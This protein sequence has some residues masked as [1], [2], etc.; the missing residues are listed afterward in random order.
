M[1]GY[2]SE[3]VIGKPVTVLMPEKFRGA[4][5]NHVINFGADTT[6]I[7][8][9]M[10]REPVTGL[11]KNGEKFSIEASI[12]KLTIDGT[13]L[14]TA[15]LLDITERLQAE[16]ELRQLRNYLEN[17]INSMP[18]VLIG[19]DADGKITQWNHQAS[20]ETDIEADHAIGQPLGKVLPRYAHEMDRIRLAIETRKEQ[21]EYGLAHVKDG[22]TVYEDVSIYPLIANGVQGA[23]MRIDDVT[24]QIRIKEMMIQSEKMASVGGLAAG[25]A[26]EINNPLGG[27]IQTAAVLRD[28]L[29]GDLKANVR[30][31][32]EAGISLEQLAQY[33]EA[34]GINRML[35]TIQDSGQRAA[36]IVGNMLGFTRKAES[37][38]SSCDLS[39]LVEQSLQLAET[40]YDMKKSFD[41]RQI[42]VEL[43]LDDNLPPVPCQS[44]KMQQVLLNLLKN[45]SQAMFFAGTETPTITIK[46]GASKGKNRVFISVT[47]NGPG[48]D[49]ATRKRVFE[50]FFTTKPVGVGTGLGLSVS[51]FIITENH[52]GELLVD[53]E[54]GVGTSFTILLPI[55]RERAAND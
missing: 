41:F 17:I 52:F 23:V 2:Q 54:T 11:R 47:D 44:Q 55:D 22:D 1:F 36:E 7:V 20:K 29:T 46:T 32:E 34:R 50:P 33:N 6:N 4:H 3:E 28:R 40:D 38:T 39:G 43:D 21:A 30:A 13:T 5:A 8:A 15:S 27:M 12:S 51:Y 31:A 45:A 19:V 53:S 25:M 9:S 26:H 48:M 18:S 35:N 16:R 14:M 24:E 37:A 49:E 42:N 10:G